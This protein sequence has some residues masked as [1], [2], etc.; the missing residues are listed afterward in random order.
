MR[1]GP[2]GQ[3][4]CF[5]EAGGGRVDLLQENDNAG[6]SKPPSPSWYSILAICSRSLYSTT[7][8]QTRNTT[9]NPRSSASRRKVKDSLHLLLASLEGNFGKVVIKDFC[10]LLLDDEKAAMG[11]TEICICCAMVNGSWALPAFLLTNEWTDLRPTKGLL[12]K[13]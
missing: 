6:S 13:S 2:S 5:F 12:L 3:R 11:S 1:C 4:R 9:Q 10:C 7:L 8:E